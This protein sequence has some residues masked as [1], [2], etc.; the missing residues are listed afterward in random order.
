MVGEGRSSYI[1][2]SRSEE[3]TFKWTWEGWEE[4]DLGALEEGQARQ[5]NIKCKEMKQEG[6]LCVTI[7]QVGDAG[8][9]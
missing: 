7:T 2:L 3:L 8:V 6:N 1:R 9:R 5:G 4:G